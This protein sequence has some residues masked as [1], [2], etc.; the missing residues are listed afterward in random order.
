MK[1]VKSSH[2]DVD[3]ILFYNNILECDIPIN[4]PT[5]MGNAQ[6]PSNANMTWAQQTSNNIGSGDRWDNKTQKK[7][8][9]KKIKVSNV[10]KNESAN[11]NPYDKLGNMMLDKLK[12]PSIF[13]KTSNGGVNTKEFSHS[14]RKL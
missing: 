1:A 11:V 4:A 5:G 9:R 7:P 3:D 10:K 13:S 12:I 14:I 6:P 8:K 2:V